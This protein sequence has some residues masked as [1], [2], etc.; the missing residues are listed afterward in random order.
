MISYEP[1]YELLRS[2]NMTIQEVSLAIGFAKDSLS[3]RMSRRE[4][5][6][7]PSLDRICRYLDCGIEDIFEFVP[8]GTVVEHKVTRNMKN[9]KRSFE[10][11]T[12][13]WPKLEEAINDAGYYNHSLSQALN[14]P[15]NYIARK[16]QNKKISKDSL[17]LIT[18]FLG[19]K[20]DDYIQ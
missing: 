6:S 19:L 18:D 8:D 15:M 20:A 5:I 7:M 10:S 1:L 13:D 12:V 2:R 17:K 14:K 3:S 9:R 16:K 4:S 11:V